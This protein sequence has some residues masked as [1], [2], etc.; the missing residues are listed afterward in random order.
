[1]VGPG[2]TATIPGVGAV[3]CDDVVAQLFA[4]PENHLADETNGTAGI[5]RIQHFAD[6]ETT[7]SPL[8]ISS[9][10]YDD[11]PAGTVG[12][13]LMTYTRPISVGLG[14]AALLLTGLESDA[15]SSPKV[16]FD[17]TVNVFAYDDVFTRVR[18][19]ALK[20]DGTVLGTHDLVLNYS[21]DGVPYTGHFQPRYLS[22]SDA[23]G[24]LNGVQS[25]PISV[26][27]EV[28][29]GG[30]VGAYGLVEDI[31]THDPT[32]VQATPQN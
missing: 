13:Q 4:T 2:K 26:K 12:S 16:R 31:T 1:I 17:S 11:Q 10:N 6:A 32:Y 27:V 29:E 18:L 19:T 20:S 21:A 22:A 30:R 24:N 7:S 3:C 15:S 9:R 23:T 25:A 14:E 28:I 5:V 8:I